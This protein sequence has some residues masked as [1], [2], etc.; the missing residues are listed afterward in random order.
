MLSQASQWMSSSMTKMRP[1]MTKGLECTY[2]RCKHTVHDEK[3]HRLT[4]HDSHVLT[5]HES[6]LKS[7]KVHLAVS[8][9]CDFVN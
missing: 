4:K 5:P 3:S 2:N 9:E 6:L 8:I 7:L 1:R